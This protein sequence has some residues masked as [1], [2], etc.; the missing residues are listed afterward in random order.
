M[1]RRMPRAFEFREKGRMI[2]GW[3]AT[4]EEMERLYLDE[5]MALKDTREGLNAFME[6]REPI[7]QNK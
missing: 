5:L 1:A 2:R 4:V 3:Q 7:W 6:K